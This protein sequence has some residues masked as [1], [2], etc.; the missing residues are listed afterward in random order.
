[1]ATT[2][3]MVQKMLL[4][5]VPYPFGSYLT[6]YLAFKII[7]VFI[8]GNNGYFFPFPAFVGSFNA[9]AI[10]LF[11]ELVMFYSRFNGSTREAYFSVGLQGIAERDIVT[12]KQIIDRTVDE[13]IA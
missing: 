1:M 9:Y 5:S 4:S 6:F 13:V 7:C 12:V 3:E 8:C 10:V 11:T 2:T